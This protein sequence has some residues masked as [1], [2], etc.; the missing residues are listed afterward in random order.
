LYICIPAHNEADTVGVLL[1]RIRK[2][3]QSFPREY[4]LIVCND[5]SNDATAET[6]SAYSEVLPLTVLGGDRRIGYA[7]ALDA[8]LR[9]ASARCRYPRRDA[10]IVMQADFTDPPEHIPDLVKRFE[11]GAD[12]VVAQQAA[13]GGAPK[14]VRRLRRVAPWLLRPFVS[15]AGVRDP[16]GSFRLFRVSVLR[17]AIRAAGAEPLARFDSW[18]GNVDLLLATAPHARRVETEDVPPRYDL[19]PRD[20]RVRPLAGALALLRFGRL[21]RTRRPSAAGAGPA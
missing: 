17:D 14:P 21:A 10:V 16:L 8:L 5:G 13:N 6:L 12:I 9:A 2:V 11:G 15:V 19:R 20:S 3:F 1:W 7:R 18:A 4:E